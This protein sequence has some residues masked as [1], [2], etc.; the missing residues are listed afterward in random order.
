MSLAIEPMQESD[1]GEVLALER[2]IFSDPWSMGMF[3]EELSRKP[4]SLSLVA[5]DAQGK[6][7]GY[8]NAIAIYDELHI[9]NIAVRADLR[10]EGI[11]GTLLFQALDH[12]RRKAL[13]L[14]TLEVRSANQAALSFY[15][16]FGFRSVAIRKQYYGDDDAVVMVLDLAVQA[17]PRAEKT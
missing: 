15:D 9:G 13:I 6:L 12:A 5:R 14:A 3:R 4:P 1:L 7:A 16:H 17:P 2:D 10:R 11:G 8:L